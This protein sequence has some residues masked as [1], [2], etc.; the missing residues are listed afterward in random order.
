MEKISPTIARRLSIHAQ[1]LAESPQTADKQTILKIIRR[2]G[3]LQIDPINVVARSP[4]LVLWSRVGQYDLADLEGLL[5]QDKLLFEYWAHAA[6]IVL[7]EDFPLF[8]PWMQKFAKGD[9]SWEL[10]VAKW[11]ETNKPLYLYILKE[12]AERGPLYPDQIDNLPDVVPWASNGWTD[13]RNVPTMLNML[14]EQGKITVTNRQGAGFGLKKQWALLEY[15]LPQWADH[16]PW[17]EEKIVYHAAQK[18]LQAL[19][20]GTTNHI[21]N[22]FMR[23]RYPGLDE[24]VPQ[25]KKE[26][27]II[28]VQIEDNGNIWPE[29][30]Y[31][32]RD[33]L[34]LLESLIDGEWQQRTTLLSPFDN[35]I[36]DRDRTETLFNFHYRSEIYTPKA[37]RKYGY[38]VMPILHGDQIIGRIDPKL[39]RKK[40]QMIIN[41]IHLEEDLQETAEIKAAVK[42]SIEELARFLKAK[43]TIYLSK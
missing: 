30:W 43:E 33:N 37:K 25:L 9:S 5:W 29:E 23:G 21:K 2:I 35:L 7:T 16:N 6:S 11:L 4:L 38:Y 1:Q 32:H 10:R 17:P 12:L 14:W 20:V 15:H 26:G 39:D 8:Q 3:C 42:E 22:H 28:P 18:S 41:A 19:G 13:S 36:C 24:I 31:V 27:L 34:P 40:K